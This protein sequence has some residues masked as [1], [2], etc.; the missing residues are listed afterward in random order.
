MK[1]KGDEEAYRAGPGSGSPLQDELRDLRPA[2]QPHGNP[3][4]GCAR[5]DI[6]ECSLGHLVETSKEG[7]QEIGCNVQGEDL[8][9]V[10]V[11]RKDQV[12]VW[13]SLKGSLGSQG[14]VS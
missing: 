9:S 8:P 6:H 12:N 5:A 10:C 3:V 14:L 4:V 7:V 11:P 2:A 13:P 1:G